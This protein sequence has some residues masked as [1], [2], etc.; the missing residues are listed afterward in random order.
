[1]VCEYVDVELLPLPF[2]KINS[3]DISS[4]YTYNTDY[5]LQRFCW[6]WDII[7]HSVC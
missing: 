5:Y 4:I 1:M 6:K 2:M 3:I 7:R